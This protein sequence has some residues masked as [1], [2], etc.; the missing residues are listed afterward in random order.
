MYVDC[1]LVICISY[2]IAGV[3]TNLYSIP[4]NLF[5][6]NKL[7]VVLKAGG[8]RYNR[9]AIRWLYRGCIELF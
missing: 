9:Y 7:S 5:P 1:I 4:L 3:V 2:Y 6:H 8:E